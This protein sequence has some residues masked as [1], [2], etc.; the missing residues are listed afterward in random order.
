MDPKHKDVKSVA[1]ADEIEALFVQTSHG[2]SYGGRQAHSANPGAHDPV[3][4]RSAR[5]VTGHVSSQE[6]VDSWDKGPDNLRLQSAQCGAL[7][8]PP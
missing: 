4:L 3:L 7:H 6:F 2:M 8:L 5:R 1:E